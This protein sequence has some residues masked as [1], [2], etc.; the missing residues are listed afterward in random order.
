MRRAGDIHR[1]WRG[2]P[3]AG[4]DAIIGGGTCLILAP[5]PDDESLGCGGLIAACCAAK[6]PP[7]VAVLTDGTG[8]H[9]RSQAWPAPALRAL[10]AQEARDAVACLGLP[11]ERIVFLNRKDSAAPAAGA[12]F[13]A[14]V[15]ELAALVEPGCTSI[16]TTW[17]HDP[18]CDHEAAAAIA[19][20][21]AKRCGVRLVVYPV[22]GWTLPDDQTIADPASVGWR[23]DIAAH[24]SLKRAAIQAHRSQYGGL[25]TDDPDGFQL[26]PAL[27]S[28][29]ETPFE[30]FLAA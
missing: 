13:D 22:W 15:A 7:L 20:A 2:L 8:S 3:V 16:L 17:R 27:L 4:L 9:P 26:P 18:H 10:R 29:F 11:A 25:I 19:A 14:A 6:R 28:G 24:L 5:H 12:D 30:T 23:L 21:A 1:D